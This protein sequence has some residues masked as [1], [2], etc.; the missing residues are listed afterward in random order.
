MK[1]RIHT[2]KQHRV[3]V[4]RIN[5]K[6][7]K[8]NQSGKGRLDERYEQILTVPSSVNRKKEK[9]KT[10][11]TQDNSQEV[12]SWGKMNKNTHDRQVAQA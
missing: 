2:E 8:V 10:A 7:K 12:A 1:P 5:T 6:T 9:Q 11:Y 3:N 4:E